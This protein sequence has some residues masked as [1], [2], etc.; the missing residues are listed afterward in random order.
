MLSSEQSM[1]DR[2]V[3]QLR[4]QV[5]LISVQE[6]DLGWRHMNGHQ[7]GNWVSSYD[8]RWNHVPS[9]NKGDE[10]ESLIETKNKRKVR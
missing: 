3:T 7:Q 4:R 8:S 5:K 10:E 2:P 1:F 6:R 9:V